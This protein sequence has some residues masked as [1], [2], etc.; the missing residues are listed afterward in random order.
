MCAHAYLFPSVVSVYLKL[1]KPPVG[2]LK[3]SIVEAQHELLQCVCSV[4]CVYT[5]TASY[6]RSACNTLKP[7]VRLTHS[8]SLFV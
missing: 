6:R 1:E 4:W 7:L 2:S 5:A 3:V 8:L